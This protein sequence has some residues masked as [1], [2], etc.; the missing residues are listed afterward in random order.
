MVETHGA[1]MSSKD[2]KD[3]RRV[4]ISFGTEGQPSSGRRDGGRLQAHDSRRGTPAIDD[5]PTQ[6][7]RRRGAF[8]AA[9]SNDV[10]QSQNNTS[11]SREVINEFGTNTNDHDAEVVQ[12]VHLTIHS[13]T[14]LIWT[15]AGGT[16]NIWLV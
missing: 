14:K 1:S 9:L 15:P 8:G 7:D 12:Y 11:S 16:Q 5:R 4:D 10:A 2:L 13:A 3:T 6:P